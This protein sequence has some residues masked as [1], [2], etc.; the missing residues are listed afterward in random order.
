MVPRLYR[1]GKSASGLQNTTASSAGCPD[2][3]NRN[4]VLLTTQLM[5]QIRR[6]L[7]GPHFRG[8]PRRF[9][10][11]NTVRRGV[12]RPPR[13]VSQFFLGGGGGHERG[14]DLKCGPRSGWI[15]GRRRLP[16]RL[17]NDCFLHMPLTLALAAGGTV[18]GQRLAP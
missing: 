3:A 4:T 9:V 8:A 11:S 7:S 6:D 14:R 15:G 18:A 17:G 12:Q 2:G 1:E 10:M 13:W 16:T 5:Q